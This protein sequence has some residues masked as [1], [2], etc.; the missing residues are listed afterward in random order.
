MTD[1]TCSKCPYWTDIPK[2]RNDMQE[3]VCRRF[4]SVTL[5]APRE[6]CGEHPR[7]RPQQQGKK[8]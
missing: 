2:R 6:W 4:P 5:K 7:R 1:D 8:G 3:G